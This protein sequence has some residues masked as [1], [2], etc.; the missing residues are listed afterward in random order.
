MRLGFGCS[1]S[2][3]RGYPGVEPWSKNPTGRDR[4]RGLDMAVT[5]SAV[6]LGM[7]VREVLSEEG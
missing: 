5:M 3:W 2:L 4:G 7:G 1:S 6:S